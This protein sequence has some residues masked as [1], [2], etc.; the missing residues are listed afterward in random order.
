M[1]SSTRAAQDAVIGADVGGTHTD[2]AVIVGGRIA[3]GKALTTYDDFSRGVLEAVGVA[4]AQLG[5]GL[6][7][8]L[9]CT[10]FFTNCTTVVTNAIAELRG[11]RVGLLVTAGFRD[12]L[13]FAGGPRRYEFDDHLQLNAPDIVNRAAIAEIHERVDY[14]GQILVPLDLAQ[15]ESEVG[16]L[17]DEQEIEALAICFLSSFVNP[18]HELAAERRV[19]ER[20]PELFVTTSHRASQMIGENRRWTTAVMNSFVQKRAEA[21]LDSLTSRLREAG[22][23][24]GLAFF[25]GLGGVVSAERAKAYPL[26]LLGAG[27]AGG[28]IGANAL[29][30]RM[31]HERILVADMGGTSFDT[32]IINNNELHIEQ[33]HD[34][35]LFETGVSL[36]DVTSV[37][38]GGGSIAWVDQRGVPQLG[39]HSAGSAPGPAAYGTGG[40]EPTVT[41]AMVSLGFIDPDHY[42]GGRLRLQRT[43][44]DDS[45]RRVLG[46]RFD[47][48]VDE[49]AAAVHDLIVVNMANAMREVSIGKGYDP[50]TFALFAYGGMLP[51]FCMQIAERLGI[52]TVVIPQNSSVFCARGLLDADFVSRYDQIVGWDLSTTAAVARVNELA[53]QLIETGV[54][55]MKDEGFAEDDIEVLRTADFRFLGQSSELTIPLPNRPLR[56]DDAS[57]LAANFVE[58]YER[59]YGEGTSWTNVAVV[60]L[61][62]TITVTGRQAKPSLGPANMAPTSPEAML[63]AT[64]PVFLPSLREWRDIPVYDDHL[65]TAGSQVEGPAILDGYDT[66]IYVPPASRIERD[67]YM[68]YVMTRGVDA[69]L[70]GAAGGKMMSTGGRA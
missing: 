67:R 37:G 48:S 42:L 62:Y 58:L 14:A 55:D 38:A 18:G 69:Q 20:F 2:V 9:S 11:S 29:G 4:A 12:T 32:G 25:Q 47:W 1:S 59:T 40:T 3:C 51:L 24:G 7:E 50:R 66:T 34:I 63:Q 27:P 19:K 43:L 49:A 44:A 46:D 28:A 5:L 52:D 13:R 54:T 45:L 60:L 70:A 22:L 39:P 15:V 57:Q 17:V 10:K 35:G 6:P 33:N 16:R 53:E 64:R 31:G 30:K 65:F 8:L 61:N 21:Y 41:D 36:I 56:D 23:E 68:N 26:A